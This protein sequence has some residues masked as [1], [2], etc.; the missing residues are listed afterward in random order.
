MYLDVDTPYY[1]EAYLA[2][3]GGDYEFKLGLMTDDS[4]YTSKDVQG[5]MD[6]VQTVTVSSTYL[7]DVQ[8]STTRIIS[9]LIKILDEEVLIY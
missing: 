4:K 5:A 8:V 3:G 6:E 9:T 1:Y 2:D 7:P